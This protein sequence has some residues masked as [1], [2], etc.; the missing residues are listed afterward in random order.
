MRA[1]REALD[2]LLQ[3]GVELESMPTDEAVAAT[4]ELDPRRTAA[5]LHLTC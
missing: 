4:G 1:D 2:E 3:R 5:A